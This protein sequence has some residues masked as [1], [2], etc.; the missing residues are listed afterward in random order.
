MV[1]VV[2]KCD[3][4]DA[5]SDVDQIVDFVSG[6]ARTLLGVDAAAVY[7]VAARLALQA[8]TKL[9]ARKKGDTE[10]LGRDERW[11]TSRFAALETFM[12]EFLTGAGAALLFP[13]LAFL[14]GFC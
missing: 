12:L 1:F 7:P 10:A 2:N 9:G 5:P 11:R 8:K 3:I 4:F 6:N 13:T 14:L